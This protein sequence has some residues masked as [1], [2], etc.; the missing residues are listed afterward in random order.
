MSIAATNEN[1]I[2]TRFYDINRTDAR[3][4]ASRYWPQ[5][6]DRLRLPLVTVLVGTATYQK[7]GTG[8]LLVRRNFNLHAAVGSWSGGVLA[9]TAQ[10]NSELLCAVIR[11]LYAFDRE[12]L[13]LDWKALNGVVKAELLNDVGLID[14]GGIATLVSTVYVE[15][16]AIK[17]HDSS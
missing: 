11:D 6:L 1:E 10:Q 3:I 9:E 7:E 14:R 5:S 17:T 12:R 16:R 8:L 4:S 2:C 13:Q 15:Y